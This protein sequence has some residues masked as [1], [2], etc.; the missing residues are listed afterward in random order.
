M[1]GPKTHVA[2]HVG[3]LA[4]QL[5]LQGVGQ[6]MVHW[7]GR[8]SLPGLLVADLQ[9][10][11]GTLLWTGIG[12]QD[13]NHSWLL[14]NFLL[15]LLLLQWCRYLTLQLRRLSGV[16]CLKRLSQLVVQGRRPLLP[17]GLLVFELR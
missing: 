6:L 1:T 8:L 3:E 17:T 12:L 2:L 9:D 14:F 5:G 16:L 11:M 4:G 13:H 15:L 7:M 10:Q